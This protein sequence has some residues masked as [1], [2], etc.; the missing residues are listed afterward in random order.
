MGCG[1]NETKEKKEKKGCGCKEKKEK[2]EKKGC[3]C[4][5]KKPRCL[6]LTL[7]L[8]ASAFT[9]APGTNPLVGYFVYTAPLN[10]LNPNDRVLLSASLTANNVGGATAYQGPLFGVSINATINPTLLTLYVNQT[11]GSLQGYIQNTTLNA[12]LTLVFGC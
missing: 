5:D 2:K 4:D 3:G 6:P 8:P 1:C 7:T 10:S 11:V 12:N 9:F